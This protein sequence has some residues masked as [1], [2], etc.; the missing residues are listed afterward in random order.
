[1][2]SRATTAHGSLSPA[3]A[4]FEGAVNAEVYR[5]REMKFLSMEVP[6][7]AD[8]AGDSIAK[9]NAESI[10]VSGALRNGISGLFREQ[11]V[12]NDHCEQ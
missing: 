7:V 1:M 12:S 6:N 9:V 2:G 3:A 8:F 5:M 11:H 10:A 4:Q